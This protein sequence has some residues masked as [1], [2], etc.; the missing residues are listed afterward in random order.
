MVAV[1]REPLADAAE[2]EALAELLAARPDTVVVH[3]GLAAA[4]PVAERIVY[5][6]GAGRANAEA[7]AALLV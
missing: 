2:G 5:A 1:V 6:H 7:V 3:T 4:A